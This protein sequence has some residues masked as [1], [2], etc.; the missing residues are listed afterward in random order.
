MRNDPLSAPASNAPIF[1]PSRQVAGPARRL[2]WIVGHVVIMG[3]L[4]LAGPAWAQGAKKNEQAAFLLALVPFG[5]LALLS[6]QVAIIAAFPRFTRRCGAAVRR[7]RWQT[8]LSGLAASLGIFLL[9]AVVGSAAEGAAAIPLALG[10]LAAA[11]GS[12]GLSLEVGRWAVARIGSEVPL[13]P[14][15]QLLIGSSV[16]G[17]GGL[18]VPCLGQLAWIVAF[19]MAVGGSIYALARGNALDEAPPRQADRPVPPPSPLSAPAQPGPDRQAVDVPPGPSDA[20]PQIEKRDQ[21][22]DQVF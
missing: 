6:L 18:L 2:G 9:A 22:D 5:F 3:L 16:L 19:C 1:R 8:G 14:T 10:L 7:Y 21:P 12:V 15:A 17:W 4:L 11:A 20:G 13:H